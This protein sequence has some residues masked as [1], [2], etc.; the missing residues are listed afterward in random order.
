MSP[1]IHPATVTHPTVAQRERGDHFFRGTGNQDRVSSQDQS[2]YKQRSVRRS[3]LTVGVLASGL[4][5]FRTALHL[6]NAEH[7][8]A[9]SRLTIATV[10][11]GAFVRDLMADGQVVAAV[12]PTLYAPVAGTIVLRVHS[13]DAVS[14]GDVVA[15]MDSLE[16]TTRLVQEKATLESL[17]LD[18][19]RS[20]LEAERKLAE[21]KMAL[22]QAALDD[23]AA[24]RDLDRSRRA[25]SRGAYA[26]DQVNKAEDGAAKAHLSLERAQSTADALPKTN[27]FEVGSRRAAVSRQTELVSDLQRQIA[28][29]TVR[30][31]V[32]GLVGQINVAEHAAV[33]RDAAL[34]TIVDLS[35]LEVQIR[36]PQGEARDIAATMEADLEADGNHWRGVVGAV[37]PQVIDGTVIARVRF[38][39]GSPA[40][41]RQGQRVQ[42]R[43]IIDRRD[44]V[45]TVARGTFVDQEGTHFAYLVRENI[46]TRIPVRLGPSSVRE[47]EV[48]EG[49][50]EADQIVV[51][52]TDAFNG[53]DRVILTQ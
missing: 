12:S 10:K 29:L 27:A 17:T 3:I 37:S 24:T 6:S 1:R 47:V 25:Y 26:L 32:T 30:A 43:I 22:R 46:A 34:L 14:R 18:W 8:V 39:G 21:A 31:P 44:N 19:K 49:L 2:W 9:R 4:L 15:D 28:A 48:L 11:R 45:L 7:S 42:V 50:S 13:G 33:A 23:T 20:G 5:L 51:S 41:L 53:S 16:L 36:V 35:A 52:G 38:A 40:E